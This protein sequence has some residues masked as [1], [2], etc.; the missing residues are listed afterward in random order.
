MVE[1]SSPQPWD[2]ARYVE[3]AAYVPRLGQ[4][5]VDLLAPQPGERVLDIGCGDGALTAALAQSGAT[6]AGV[7]ASPAMVAA[8]QARGLDARVAD[9]AALPGGPDFDGAFDA[10][11]TNAAL[12]W[13]PDHEAVAAGMA[14]MLKPGGRVV[15]ELGGH[16]NV[17]AIVTALVAVLGRRG[18]DASVIP[19]TFPTAERFAARLQRHGFTVDSC[20]LIHRPTPLETGMAAWLEVFATGL[21]A[22]LDPAEREAARDEA[23]ALLR[24]ALCDDQGNWTGDYVRLRFTARLRRRKRRRLMQSFSGR[25]FRE[26]PY[27]SRLPIDRK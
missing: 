10:V 7:D 16:G 15:G 2:P 18:M 9:A 8:A 17:A 4:P 24:P 5:L 20:A 19:W 25:L 27:P 6:V 13:V 26:W 23:V 12:H 3:H 11:F 14:R 21:F 22:R 1:T